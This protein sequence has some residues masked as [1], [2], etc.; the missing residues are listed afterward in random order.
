MNKILSHMCVKIFYFLDNNV[1]SWF[2]MHYW[3]VFT[4]ILA[5]LVFVLKI[6]PD[7]MKNREPYSLKKILLF[8]NLFQSGFNLFLLYNV[9]LTVKKK[10]C[11]LYHGQ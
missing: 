2:L 8:Y 6:G 4:I 3:P 1:D 9:S 11:I 10:K 7:M 5:Y